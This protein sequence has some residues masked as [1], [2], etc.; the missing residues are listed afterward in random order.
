MEL[1]VPVAVQTLLSALRQAGFEAYA[2]GGCVRDALLH[3]QPHDW[4]LTTSALPEQMKTVFADYPLFDIGAQHGTIGVRIDHQTIEV[5]TFRI[6][7]SYADNRHPNQVQFTGKLAEDLSRRDFTVNAMAYSKETGLLDLFGGQEDLAA[8][9]ICCVGNPDRRFQEDA[10]RLLR[11]VRFA[12]VLSFQVEPETAAAIERNQELLCHISAERITAELHSF[13]NGPGAGRLLLQFAGLFTVALPGI[14]IT[15][16]T[17]QTVDRAPEQFPLRLALLLTS[18]V[19]PEVALCHLRL[20]NAEKDT[21]LAL[22]QHQT[23]PLPQ[24]AAG[25]R[26]LLFRLGP[27]CCSLLADFHQAQGAD[28][29]LF[30]S[31]L[32]EVLERKDCYRIRDLALD[33]NQLQKLGCPPG[34]QVGQLLERLLFQ[35]MEEKVENTRS[36]LTA[37]ALKEIS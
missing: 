5:T 2:V 18:A 30:R 6:D 17:G 7:G 23:D 31:L 24:D 15:E 37:A 9:R 35:V 36:A 12:S 4:D 32:Q 13:L 34:P 27:D 1:Q 8:K 29:T 25:V 21:V 22:L 11:A 16:E 3:K 10:L 26:I 20:S 33:G 19:D 28:V 14:H